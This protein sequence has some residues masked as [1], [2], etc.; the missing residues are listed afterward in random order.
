MSLVAAEFRYAVSHCL[1]NLVGLI[2]GL[3]PA[4]A[5]TLH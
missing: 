1:N 3:G 2:R 4:R 5:L